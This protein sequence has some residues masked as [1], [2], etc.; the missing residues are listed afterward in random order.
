MPASSL[1]TIKDNTFILSSSSKHTNY[2]NLSHTPIH[3]SFDPMN[4]AF[5]IFLVLFF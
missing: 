5:D 3:W 1:C 4:A 2:L